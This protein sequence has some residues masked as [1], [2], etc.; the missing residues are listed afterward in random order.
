MKLKEIVLLETSSKMKLYEFSI[1]SLFPNYIIS[2][3]NKNSSFPTYS[4]K[5]DRGNV[6][7]KFS[8][9][10]TNNQLNQLDGFDGELYENIK[11]HDKIFAKKYNLKIFD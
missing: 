4:I 10:I 2:K 8:R 9:F 11:L 1:E 6:V 3:N 7:G 5:D